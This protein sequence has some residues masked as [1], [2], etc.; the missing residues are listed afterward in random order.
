MNKT[1]LSKTISGTVDPVATP[2]LVLGAYVG[3][4]FG[5]HLVTTGNLAGAWKIEVSCS[6]TDGQE[7]GV[8]I[9]SGFQTPAGAAIAAA[10]GSTL[11]QYVQTTALNAGAFKVTFTPTSG[12][13]DAR[14]HRWIPD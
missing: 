11:K 3:H 1:E 8:D 2:W 7:D 5:L 13:G 14:V 9:T 4:L 6:P 10:V 12:T